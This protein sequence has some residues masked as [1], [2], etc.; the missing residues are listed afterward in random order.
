MKEKNALTTQ[1]I[2]GLK[3]IWRFRAKKWG[4]KT[5][6]DKRVQVGISFKETKP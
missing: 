4:R 1:E 5:A 3:F 2:G 6:V